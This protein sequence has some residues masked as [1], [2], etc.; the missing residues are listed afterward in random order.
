V[1][2]PT[3]WEEIYRQGAQNSIWPWTDLVSYVM[4]YARPSGGSCKVL[5]LGFGAGAN[6]AF[7]SSLG[8]EY[9]GTEGSESAVNRVSS[10]FANQE[11]ITLACCDFTQSIPFDGPF[12]LVV[13]RSSLTHNSTTAIRRCL[14][15][16]GL[17]MKPGAKFIG[18]DW[19]STDNSQFLAGRD[20]GD[21]HTRSDFKSGQFKDVGTVHFS[22]QGHL[23]DLFSRG[24]FEI[25]RLEHKRSD[26][27]M[28][29]V[30]DRMAWW[31]FVAVK[32]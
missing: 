27:V 8:V 28:P 1:A 2:F 23:M 14:Q 21:Y 24:G 4:R 22:D 26:V 6:V 15:V 13:D 12:D 11:R 3:E 17:R 31:N 7:F 9:F 5:E 19:F 30:S 10:R 25:E 32:Q 18:I 29:N 16:I 20:F